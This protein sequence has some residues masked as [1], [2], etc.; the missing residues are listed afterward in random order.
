MVHGDKVSAF[1][2]LQFVAQLGNFSTHL[3]NGLVAFFQLLVRPLTDT[4]GEGFPLR[5]SG[6]KLGFL[7]LTLFRQVSTNEST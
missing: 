4:I 6:L 7:F 1:P 2:D 3:R 5:A